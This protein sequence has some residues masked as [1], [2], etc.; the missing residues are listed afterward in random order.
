MLDHLPFV[1]SLPH[2]VIMSFLSPA[3][4]EELAGGIQA[5]AEGKHI[6]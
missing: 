4:Q 2:L 6:H 5:A 3:A 1:A